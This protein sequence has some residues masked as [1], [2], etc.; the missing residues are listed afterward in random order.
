MSGRPASS[1]VPAALFFTAATS[2][3]QHV[4]DPRKG[5]ANVLNTLLLSAEPATPAL[6]AAAAQSAA[7]AEATSPKP[8]TTPYPVEEVPIALAAHFI[9][10][11]GYSG[12]PNA[13]PASEG[14]AFDFRRAGPCAS[15]AGTQQCGIEWD[16]WNLVRALIPRGATV[17]ELGARYGTHQLVTSALPPA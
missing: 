12:L 5:S 15:Y 2:A 4:L 9:E 6:S 11:Q 14:A 3:H 10:Q 7:A 13:P 17:L 8:A 1:I 16:E